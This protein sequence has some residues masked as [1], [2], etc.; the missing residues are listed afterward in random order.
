MQRSYIVLLSSSALIIAGIV[1]TLISAISASQPFLSQDIL[2]TEDIIKSKESRSPTL[3]AT[4]LGPIMYL[5]IKSEPSNIPLTAA[6]KDPNGLTVS[7]STFSQDLVTNFKPQTKGKYVLTITNQGTEEVK[8]DTI[9]G[10]LSNFD[11]N[12]KPNY[13]ALGGILIGILLIVISSIA[14]A[15]GFI[16]L[17][18]DKTSEYEG[19]MYNYSIPKFKA[20]KILEYFKGP[21]DETMKGRSLYNQQQVSS[22]ADEL[23]KIAKLKEQGILSEEEF[24]QMK[25]D[26]LNYFTVHYPK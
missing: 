21:A 8:T 11:E 15:I 25:Q 5:V 17:L 23:A 24:L 13:G 4:Q 12:Q 19:T 22:F 26:L 16:M 9:L 1:L 18:K 14:L 3:N 10:Y 2:V 6:V 20:R 7:S